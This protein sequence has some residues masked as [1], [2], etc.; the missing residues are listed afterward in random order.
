MRKK[1]A[2]LLEELKCCS[3]FTAFYNENA[4]QLPRVKLSDELSI[5][6]EK[7]GLIKFDV[8][9]RSELS[10]VY[11]YQIFSGLRIPERK[12]LL[13]LLIAMNLSLDDVQ[14]LLKKT[15]YSQLYA[16]NEFDC[17]LIYGICKKLSVADI[18]NM[19]YEYLGE[20]L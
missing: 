6:L 5:L 20:T 9:Q 4:E 14:S 1:T 11:G 3:D 18:N 7:H 2:D 10:E 19:L 13:C 15:G 8:I 16:K 12:K 17:I